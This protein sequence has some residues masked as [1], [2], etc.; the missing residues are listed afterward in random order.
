MLNPCS[1]FFLLLGFIAWVFMIQEDQ[2]FFPF[3]V[4]ISSFIIIVVVIY[5]VTNRKRIAGVS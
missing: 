3:L 5:I 2:F 4:F 1:K